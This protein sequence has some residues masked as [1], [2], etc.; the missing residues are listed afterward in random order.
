MRAFFQKHKNT[1]FIFLFMVIGAELYFYNSNWGAPYYFHPDERNIAS[2]VSQLQFPNQMNPHFFAYGSL[3]IYAIYFISVASNFVSQWL[4]LSTQAKP[5]TASFEQA[6]L[7]GRAFSACFAICLIPILF[8]IGRRLRNETTGIF[9]AFFAV[10]SVS[11]IQ[12]AH[13][14][15]FEMWL[16]FFTVI[17]FGICLSYF[18]KPNTVTLGLMAFVFGILVSVKVTSLA[19]IPIPLVLMVLHPFIH[20]HKQH[21]IIQFKKSILKH[22]GFLSILKN[23]VLFTLISIL[24]YITTNP[25]VF[26]DQKDFLSSMH[27]ES[28]VALGTEAV[29]Y[30][31]NFTNT[32]PVL[33]Q[34]FHVYP[35]LLNPVMLVLFALSFLYILFATFKQKSAPFLFLITFFL[36]LFLSQ[37]VL[38]VKWTRYMVPTIP[39]MYLMIA[40]LLTNNKTVHLWNK[41]GILKTVKYTGMNILLLLCMIFAFSYFTTAFIHPDSRI[42][43]LMDA[44]AV[45]PVNAQ[46]LA[47][48]SDLGVVP[49]QDAFPHLVTFNFYD[50]DQN[51]QTATQAQLKKQIAQA[52]YIILPSQRILQSRLENPKN[53]PK[54]YAFYTSLQNGQLGFHKIYET[55]CDIFCKITY[56]NDPVYWWEQT[57]TVFDHPTVFIFK[58]DV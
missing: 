27:Y 40:L 5:F 23:L 58:K 35:F 31:Q 43:A 18:Y 16:T 47:E 11:F 57:V 44:Q 19:L 42:S 14:G 10:T 33:Y 25:F 26:L 55:P 21:P 34:L 50:L 6:I 1:I 12:F 13:Y 17:L 20:A 49:F 37:V 56:L 3:P 41:N 45:I 51:S 38:Y 28:G 54:G 30:T 9:S 8:L 53:F 52:Q 24:I 2:A 46:I 7:V 48:P 4:Q 22:F 15:T 29:F 32:T 36:I 39:F